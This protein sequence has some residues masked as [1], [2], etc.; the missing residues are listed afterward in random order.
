MKTSKLRSRSRALLCVAAC[1][2]GLIPDNASAQFLMNNTQL[3]AH[4]PLSGFS[5][6]P[7]NGNDCWGY[8]SPSGREYALM[9]LSN[10]LAVIEVT[11]PT[12]PVIRGQIS[13]TN[14]LWGDV[15]VYQNY[16]YVSNESGG[17]ID[18]IDLS[19]VDNG[20]V[21]LVQRVTAGGLNTTHNVH[22]N[23]TSG[24]L[25]LS[26]SNIGSGRLYALSLANPANPVFA[27][28]VSSTQGSYSHDVQVVNYTSGPYAGKEIAFSSNG[29][30]GLDIYDV[31]NKSN[32]VRLS[33]STYPNLS[34]CHQAWLSED[35]NY[36][37][38]NDETD[39]VNETVI[40]DVSNLSSPVMVGSFSSGNNSTDHNLYVKGQFIYEADYRGGARI[41]CAAN[42][43]QPV[44]VGWFDSYPAN[45]SAGYNGAWSVYPYFPSG[46]L[47]ISDIESGFFVVDVSAAMSVGSLAFT[48]PK[49]RP[50]LV[51]P[52]G[53]TAIS[54]AISGE[55]GGEMQ[56]KSAMFHYNTGEGFVAVPMSPS[57][58]G[59]FQA[60]FPPVPCGSEVQYFF[61]GNLG[62]GTTIFNPAG[63]PGSSFTA[64]AASDVTALFADNFETDL[65]WTTSSIG[66]TAG[67]WQRGVPVND[68]NWEYDPATDA[69]GSGQCWLT[70]NVLGNSDVD[71]GSVTLLSPSLNLTGGNLTLSYHYYLKL[72]VIDGVDRLLVEISPNG[73]SG[74]WT[75]IAIHS[76]NS[77]GA[78]DHEEGIWTHVQITDTEIASLGVAIT[79]NMRVRFTAN[80]SG[81]A[82]I[83]EAGVDA[84]TVNKYLCDPV[85]GN[86]DVNCD[87]VVNVSDLLAVISAWGQ[88][89]AP[90]AS[91]N[92]DVAP[93][94][95]GDGQ[96]NVSD[97]LMVIS[98]WG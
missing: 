34:Y 38:V 23:E 88:C 77:V 93:A 32:M 2:V 65:G 95:N 16:C 80:D 76:T 24:Y 64:I 61:S 71:G 10:S 13:H 87:N 54:V 85:C 27:G 14:S 36:L 49:G 15:K 48:Y 42:P 96:V 78:T 17:G 33:R 5:G 51:N 44:Q 50:N 52:A 57:A 73:T 7:G 22:V 46:N 56:S 83:V 92:A 6:A 11:N 97:L 39:N 29:G 26:G 72:T 98:N 12:A 30:V 84:V 55:C 90:P 31:T 82:S 59:V 28:Q 37:Y 20:I 35:R 74:P 18:V 8:V 60:V 69:D 63:A 86:G 40:L 41:Y 94:P 1:A 47:I 58:P 43:T 21:T 79:S 70:G 89:P 3:R 66:A 19:Q 67:H 45:D 68:P 91:C 53:G 81:T 62:N 4:I 75:I 25:Y 9:C